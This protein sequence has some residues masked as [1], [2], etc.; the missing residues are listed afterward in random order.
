MKQNLIRAV[1]LIG[2]AMHPEHL[3]SNHS[4]S[5]RSDLVVHMEVNYDFY[6]RRVDC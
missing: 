6:F 4:F 1:E 3:Q 5:Q 2:K